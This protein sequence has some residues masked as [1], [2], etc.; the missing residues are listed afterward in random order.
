[1][2]VGYLTLVSERKRSRMNV[3][4]IAGPCH[5]THLH[6]T[7]DY[8]GESIDAFLHVGNLRSHQFVLIMFATLPT[9]LVSSTSPFDLCIRT[10]RV[11]GLASSVKCR[12]DVYSPHLLEQTRLLLLK[13]LMLKLCPMMRPRR[14][15][16]VLCTDFAE[17]CACTDSM[18]VPPNISVGG[19]VEFGSAISRLSSRAVCY[20]P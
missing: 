4:G 2:T 11:R 9:A 12:R 14:Q 17:T 18:L 3:L 20:Q 5:L 13:A 8:S 6:K 16:G 19:I 15:E 1:M 7:C 10:R